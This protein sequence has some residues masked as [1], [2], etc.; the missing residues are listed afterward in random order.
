MKPGTETEQLNK[1]K[2]A[3]EHLPAVNML[4]LCTL[5]MLLKKVAAQEKEN[6]MSPENLGIVFGPTLLREERGE[7]VFG[8][9]TTAQVVHF[10]IN[11]F[12]SLFPVR[13]FFY[14]VFFYIWIIIS[15]YR[16][17]SRTVQIRPNRLQPTCL[18]PTQSP[19]TTLRLSPSHLPRR[20]ITPNPPPQ[21]F[22]P[23]PPWALR[24]PLWVLHLRP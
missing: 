9:A 20:L 16:K 10:M 11:H 5:I 22:R 15:F 7:N 21:L 6:K 23:L 1:V 8:I 4:L 24:L 3:L 14:G 2:K 18:P 19:S 12:D 17:S 13:K